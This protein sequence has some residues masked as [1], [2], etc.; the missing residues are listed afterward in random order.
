M[1]RYRRIESCRCQ[2][3]GQESKEPRPSGRGFLEEVP[4]LLKENDSLSLDERTNNNFYI[5]YAGEIDFFDK[6]VHQTVFKK[7]QFLGEMLS[8]SGFAKSN[9][10]LAKEKS[11]L[12]KLNKDLLYELLAENVKLADRI[13]DYV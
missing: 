13:L 10:L 3:G 2:S 11:I 12:L 5:V 9:T 1:P 8:L 7:G 4:D 6:G